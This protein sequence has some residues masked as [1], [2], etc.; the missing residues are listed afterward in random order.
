M[1]SLTPKR[2]FPRFHAGS[3]SYNALTI[4][5]QFCTPIFC[6]LEIH[7]YGCGLPPNFRPSHHTPYSGVSGVHLSTST[8]LLHH[9]THSLRL[10]TPSIKYINHPRTPSLHTSYPTSHLFTGVP[11]RATYLPIYKRQG[12]PLTSHPLRT[13]HARPLGS[14]QFT[15]IFPM[16]RVNS[17]TPSPASTFRLL[18]NFYPTSAPLI[19]IPYPS[20]A[21][22]CNPHTTLPHPHSTRP[23]LLR[24]SSLVCHTVQLTCLYIKDK[25][26]H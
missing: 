20:S 15:Q 14:S 2:L 11:H 19:L 23:I 22:P 3:T 10:L 16:N 1:S 7:T 21:V 13:P 25:V 9:R 18:P 12:V 4:P 24:T 17:Y 26:C 8:Q 5:S 6:F